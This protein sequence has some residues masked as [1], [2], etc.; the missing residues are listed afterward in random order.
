MERVDILEAFGL[1][2]GCEHIHLECKEAGDK[3]PR[4]FWET[5]SSFANTSGGVVI[6]GVKEKR[7]EGTFEVTGVSNPYE[8]V[9]NLHDT[10]SN[11]SKVNIDILQNDSIEVVEDISGKRVILVYVP[12]ASEK[13]KP[14]YLNQNNQNSYI[15]KGEADVRASEDELNAMIR[16]SSVTSID[17]KVLKGYSIDDLD[18]STLSE[19]RGKVDA[20]FPDKGYD[21]MPFEDFL[22]TTG[23]YGRSGAGKEYGPTAG[24]IMLFGKYNAIKEI[25]PSYFLDY[26]DYRGTSERWTDRLSSDLPN[27]RE[28]NIFNFYNMVYSKLEALD[29][30]KFQLGD[31]W[32]RIDASLKPALREALVNTLVHADYSIPR[33]S[34]KILVYDDRY[35]FQNPGCMLIRP[36]DFFIGGK[37]EIRNEILMKCFRLLHLSERQGMGGSEIFKVTSDNKVRAPRIDTNLLTTELTIW[38]VDVAEYPDLNIREKKILRYIAKAGKEVTTRELLENLPEYKRDSMHKGLALLQ[39]RGFIQKRGASV[40][41]RYI[42]SPAT[43]DGSYLNKEAQVFMDIIHRSPQE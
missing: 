10:L 37:S 32:V 31:D 3:L 20:I 29:K 40:S 30:T 21:G 13:L 28:M 24:C 5:Y 14:V 1:R 22:I 23:F 17:S 18:K 27:S 39:E 43:S 19:F 8:M 34:V 25:A 9:K 12:E 7:E 11:R 6:L 41:S 2:Q 16:N 36:E 4:S 42:L 15:R 33:G 26:I 38:K 35:V